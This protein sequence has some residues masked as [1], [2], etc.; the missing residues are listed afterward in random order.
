LKRGVHRGHQS[1]TI[2]KKGK[3]GKRLAPQGEVRGENSLGE[4]DIYRKRRR[5]GR[6]NA[7]LGGMKLT[8]PAFGKNKDGERK[9]R[10]TKV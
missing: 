3:S 8:L 10:E 4:A 9:S 7:D 5:R 2:I 1:P 6:S